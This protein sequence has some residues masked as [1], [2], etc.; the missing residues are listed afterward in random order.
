MD[1]KKIK[2]RKAQ[3]TMFVIFGVII[4]FAIISVVYLIN[5]VSK[6]NEE[7]L[8]PKRYIET[9]IAE[10]LAR[11]IIPIMEGAGFVNP[12]FYILYKDEKYNY[13]CHNDNYFSQCKNLYPQLKT[14]VEGEIKKEIEDEVKTCFSKIKSEYEKRGYIVNEG[15][16]GMS[17]YILPG[18]I[19]ADVEKKLEI[20]RENE[21]IVFSKFGAYIQHD[22]YNIIDIVNAAVNDET[23]FCNFEYN[24][25]MLL[26]PQYDIQI[27]PYDNNR[28]YIIKKRSDNTKVKFAVRG[29]AF[30]Q[31]DR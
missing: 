21:T 20:T 25:Y 28:L 11:P 6:Q 9:C 24:G 30:P 23:K 14:I 15:N 13:L 5:R 31:G 29:C 7:L 10:E 19:V 27:I 2:G 17:I 4:V 12:K 26:Y 22:L 1:C 16:F 8:N 3:I 18:K